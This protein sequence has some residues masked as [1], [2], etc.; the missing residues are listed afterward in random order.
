VIASRIGASTRAWVDLYLTEMRI[1]IAEQFQYR[2]ANYFYM[3]GMIAEPVIYLVVWTTVARQQGGSVGGYDAGQ[4]AAYYIVWTLV[5]NMNIVFTPFGWEE[6]IREG[7]LSGELLRPI[8]PIHHDLG[9]F[10]GWKV[11]VIV[12]WLPIALVLSLLFQPTATLT[13]L[14]IGVF[15]V[16]IWGAYLIRS[17]NQS[18]LG[19]VTFWTTRVGP[20]FDIYFTAELLLSGRLVPLGLMP[21]WVQRVAAVLPFQ[22]TFGFP[23]EALVGNLSPGQLL[24]GLAMQGLWIAIG[25]L[26]LRRAFAFAVRRYSAVGG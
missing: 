4:F 22:Y 2:V 3:V 21:E 24:G 23:I 10:A 19:M 15:L 25:G 11:V 6:R 13:P 8:H 7:R 14:G 9:Y 5:R 26:V 20:V 16:A 12:L 1:A 17:L 18:T